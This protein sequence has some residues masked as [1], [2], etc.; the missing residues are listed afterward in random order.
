MT[1]E[2]FT[3]NELASFELSGLPTAAKNI[4][5]KAQQ[6]SWQWQARKARGGAAKNIILIV[7]RK[8]Q[9]LIYC[10][11]SKMKIPNNSPK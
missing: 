10:V 5:L 9:S 6:E 3:S 2:Y 8:P 11:S 1:K 7:Y 4:N